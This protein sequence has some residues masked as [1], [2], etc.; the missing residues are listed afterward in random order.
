VTNLTARFNRSRRLS[1]RA[2]TNDLPATT[3]PAG[4]VLEQ[5]SLATKVFPKRSALC[6]I[7][8]N[9]LVDR[10]MAHWQRSC[11][12]LRTPLQTQLLSDKFS[13]HRINLQGDA[14]RLGSLLA[15]NLSLS[16]SI[17]SKIR[18][19]QN[20]PTDCRL[21]STQYLGDRLGA[22]SCFQKCIILIMFSLAEIFIANKVRL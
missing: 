20:L 3:L 22:P 21:M 8:V 19:T 10:F 7:S 17:T 4:V 18:V 15:N 16:G 13:R 11:N 12:L 5:F 9:I 14:A 6:L 2:P 1:N